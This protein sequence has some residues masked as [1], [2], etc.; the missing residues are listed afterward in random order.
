MPGPVPVGASLAASPLFRGVKSPISPREA[1][2]LLVLMNHPGLLG[3]HL[4]EVA[5]LEFSASESRELRD[6]LLRCVEEG[7][8]SEQTA[9]AIEDAGL[10]PLRVRLESNAAHSTLWSVRPE[11][12]AL[13]AAESLKQALVLHRRSGALNRELRVI[14]GRL[15]ANPNDQDYAR[16]RDIQAQLSELDGTEAAL[17]GFGAM[18][19]RVNRML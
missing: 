15:T 14:E 12:D 7:Y 5:T 1:F 16:L 3:D 4:E 9:H 18:S 19:G 10:A 6:V 8:T 13:D 17:E 2:I 11:A